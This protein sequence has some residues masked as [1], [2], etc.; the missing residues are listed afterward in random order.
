[1]GRTFIYSFEDCTMTFKHPEYG[2]YTAYGTG[3]GNFSVAYTNDIA[4]HTV[5]ADLSVVIS[6]HIVKNG[7]LTLNVIQS[8]D[9]NRWLTGWANYVEASDTSEFALT[10]ITITNKSTGDSYYLTGCTH[11]K[12]ADQDY[13]A[14][15]QTRAWTIMAANIVAQ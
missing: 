1:M 2:V 9:F 14:E 10:D 4:S 12:L 3:L 11:Q 5:S 13:D 8:S 7:T 15:A 6:K